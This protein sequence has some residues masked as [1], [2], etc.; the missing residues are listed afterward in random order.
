[1]AADEWTGFVTKI[2]GALPDTPSTMRTGAAKQ[3]SDADAI[4]LTTYVASMIAQLEGNAQARPKVLHLRGEGK[5]DPQIV[6]ELETGAEGVRASNR[7][8]EQK[9]LEVGRL[10]QDRDTR[11]KAPTG[12]SKEEWSRLTLLVR[13]AKSEAMLFANEPYFSAGTL[14]HVVGNMQGNWGVTFGPSEFFQSANENFG[15]FKKEIVH[16]RHGH[17]G[18]DRAAFINF[19][20]QSSKYAYRFM[21]AVAKLKATGVAIPTDVDALRA[22]EGRLLAMRQGEALGANTERVD[23]RAVGAG[24]DASGTLRMAKRDPTGAVVKK[25]N[26]DLDLSEAA[27][28]VSKDYRNATEDQKRADAGAIL[29]AM[30]VDSVAALDAKLTAVN[31][32]MNAVT[33]AAQRD[34]G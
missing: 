5:S 27:V 14:Y 33:R 17:G 16:A 3:F 9:L 2:I 1:M 18:S 32:E 22:D 25:A 12:L 28:A 6:E 34:R 30:G 10:E 20:I 7:V 31:V 15:D 8:Y 21:D 24:R 4:Y 11:A 29:D 26:G 19:A 13:K 23:E